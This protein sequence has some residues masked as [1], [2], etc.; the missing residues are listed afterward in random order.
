MLI[1]SS[2]ISINIKQSFRGI[3]LFIPAFNNLFVKVFFAELGER[4]QS[5]EHL[6]PPLSEKLN[7]NSMYRTNKSID[8]SAGLLRDLVSS[9]ESLITQPGTEN[10]F[11]LENT[12]FPIFK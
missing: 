8:E 3:F 2:Q 7:L 5:I 12:K 4:L 1:F 6:S 9:L 10:Q 11:L